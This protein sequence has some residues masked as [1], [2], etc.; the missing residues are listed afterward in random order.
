MILIVSSS[1]GC[2]TANVRPG[3]DCPIVMNLI[4]SPGHSRITN[5]DG[6]RITEY[7]GGIFERNTVFADVRARLMHIPFERES[8]DP[9]CSSNGKRIEM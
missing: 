8:H 2:T 5:R 9:S 3:S 1:S 4:L 6:Q 7:R